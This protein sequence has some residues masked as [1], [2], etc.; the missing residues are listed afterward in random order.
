MATLVKEKKKKKEEGSRKEDSQELKGKRL[1]WPYLQI[2]H[3]VKPMILIVKLLE[4]VYQIE[5][6]L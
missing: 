2:K 6:P 1:T 3:L 4:Q 5:I